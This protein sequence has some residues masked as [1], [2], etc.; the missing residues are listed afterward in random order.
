MGSEYCRQNEEECTPTTDCL[1]GYLGPLCQA[2]DLSINYTATGS[3]MCELCEDDVIII[4]I[5]ILKSIP[6]IVFT[7]AAV[8]GVKTSIH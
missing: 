5:A 6:L 8:Y 3:E 2:C 7:T 4:F 1:K